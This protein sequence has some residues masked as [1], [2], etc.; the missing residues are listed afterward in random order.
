MTRDEAL[1]EVERLQ[2]EH[3]DRDR[4]H[5]LPQQMGDAW[6]VVRVPSLNRPTGTTTESRPRPPH[7]DDPR[8]RV[9]P[10]WGFYGPP[11]G[12]RRIPRR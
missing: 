6:R 3:P 9:D 4:A 2:R 7:P 10:N 12:F 1:A 5:W 11:L 8:P